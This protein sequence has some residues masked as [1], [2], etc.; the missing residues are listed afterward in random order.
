MGW[1]PEW[2][3]AAR[4]VTERDRQIFL[5]TLVAQ[6]RTLLGVDDLSYIT[7]NDEMERKLRSAVDSPS[8][9]SIHVAARDL[10]GEYA[11]RALLEIRLHD[12]NRSRGRQVPV[13]ST[14]DPEKGLEV[15]VRGNERA[16]QAFLA[17]QAR[18]RSDF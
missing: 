3:P 14:R 15:C 1:A 18:S 5:G 10:A 17:H 16:Y 8:P 9:V 13:C 7:F 6:M 12:I 11:N 2:A 4:R